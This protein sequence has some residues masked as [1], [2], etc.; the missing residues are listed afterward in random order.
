MQ[1]KEKAVTMGQIGMTDA[2]IVDIVPSQSDRNSD[3]RK[4]FSLLARV[5]A[6]LW[7]AVLTAIFLQGFTHMVTVAR[8]D[9]GVFAA[10]A[11]VVSRACTLI[12][13]VTLGW[14]MLVRPQPLARRNGIVPMAVAFFGTYSVWLLPFLPPAAPSPSL[15][16]VSAAVS[17]TGSILIVVTVLHL[18]R[19]FSIAP[20]ARR[21]VIRGPYRIVRHPL[22]A[23][24]EIAVIGV[25]FQYAWYGALSFLIVHMALQICRMDYEESLLRAVFPDYEAYAKRTAR[26][27]P[28]IW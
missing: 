5:A 18:G 19:S 9:G 22:Y 13:Y 27:I 11:V 16:I 14:L 17:L 21:L 6:C 2:D 1:L 23:A 8:S 7:F 10:W 28:G 4:P 25:L 20:Q 24:E 3:A 26:L 15:E 12:F